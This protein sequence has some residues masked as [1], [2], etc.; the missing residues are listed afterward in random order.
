MLHPSLSFQRCM[1]L[2]CGFKFHKVR[3]NGKR[4]IFLYGTLPKPSSYLPE[5]LSL[6]F[7][8][9]N[10]YNAIP[11]AL[12][13]VMSSH[14]KYQWQRRARRQHNCVWVELAL[15]LKKVWLTGERSECLYLAVSFGSL[16]WRAQKRKSGLNPWTHHHLIQVRICASAEAVPPPGSSSCL[17]TQSNSKV[18][19]ATPRPDSQSWHHWA[20]TLNPSF[21]SL[22]W[23]ETHSP[24]NT[25]VWGIT[26][27][28]GE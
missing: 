16:I 17:T 20:V 4:V 21:S 19:T 27:G 6:A 9:I 13:H 1:Q 15:P 14:S 24:C 10:Y 26:K 5:V 2:Q 18:P 12:K 7:T 25:D 11:S 28:L 8:D 3:C 23:E 22:S